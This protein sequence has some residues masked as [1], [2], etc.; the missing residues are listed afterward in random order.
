ML[1]MGAYDKTERAVGILRANIQACLPYGHLAIRIRPAAWL[2]DIG[3]EK[4]C[5]CEDDAGVRRVHDGPR[6]YSP[7][8]RSHLV[9]AQDVEVHR[10]SGGDLP[11]TPW[12]SALGPPRLQPDTSPLLVSTSRHDVRNGRLGKQL[13]RAHNQHRKR[14][15]G[16]HPES[17][18]HRGQARISLRAVFPTAQAV[19]T[20]RRHP[21]GLGQLRDAY[22]RRFE[23]GRLPANYHLP[24]RVHSYVSCRHTRQA[25]GVH[26]RQSQDSPRRP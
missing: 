24:A 6:R 20:S 19:L 23:Q 5:H 12:S 3:V 13:T 21:L 25:G 1:G 17:R 2:R 22:H 18:H 7:P 8:P 15:N 9:T 26:A 11:M 14:R 4:C 16:Y 10:I